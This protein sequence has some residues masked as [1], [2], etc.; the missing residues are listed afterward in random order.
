MMLMAVHGAGAQRN[1]PKSGDPGDARWS[2]G[3]G[4]QGDEIRILNYARA[5][6]N[7]DPKEVKTAEPETDRLPR[8]VMVEGAGQPPREAPAVSRGGGC[9]GRRGGWT[10]EGGDGEGVVVGRW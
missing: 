9:A 8:S 10:V 2:Q 4:P 3:R 5:V 1:D 7:I 6:R